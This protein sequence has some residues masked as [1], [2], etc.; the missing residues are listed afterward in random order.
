LQQFALRLW[1]TAELGLHAEVR[2]T[3]VEIVEITSTPPKAPRVPRAPGSRGRAG[4]RGRGRGR[5]RIRGGRGADAAAAAGEAEAE[6]SAEGVGVSAAGEEDEL[7]P[8]A[9]SRLDEAADR[10][11]EHE[12][13]SEELDDEVCP[14]GADEGD[15]LKTLA[16]ELLA[17]SRGKGKEYTEDLADAWVAD[18]DRTCGDTMV[19]K[20]Q[21]RVSRDAAAKS[22]SQPSRANRISARATALCMAASASTCED[23]VVEEAFFED[24][25]GLHGDSSGNE[26]GDDEQEVGSTGSAGFSPKEATIDI[27]R[28]VGSW[29]LQ[30][31]RGA[32]CLTRRERDVD[33][34]LGRCGSV[35][36]Y[37]IK[38]SA[39]R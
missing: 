37:E 38:Q 35:T 18:G 21:Q 20:H 14:V 11:G 32:D 1:H 12:H 31:Q 24:A 23:E 34:P 26:G 22:K 7:D 17:R 30:A 6:P 36:T 2:A 13:D 27:E 19:K 8:L 28:V 9:L 3:E 25:V 39:P 33:L 4:G 29:Y 5:G 10:V 15:H 16:A